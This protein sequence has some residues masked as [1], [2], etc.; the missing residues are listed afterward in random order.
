MHV[1]QVVPTG[2]Y[3]LHEGA[4]AACLQHASVFL[5]GGL[6]LKKASRRVHSIN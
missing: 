4:S 2:M 6:L 1:V 5:V 3:V